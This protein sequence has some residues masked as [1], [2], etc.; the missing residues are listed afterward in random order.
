MPNCMRIALFKV[1]S[2]FVASTMV[3]FVVLYKN[4]GKSAFIASWN[5]LNYM[6]HEKNRNK[7]AGFLANIFNNNSI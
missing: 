7:K 1:I 2:C 6:S 4:P 3:F 5:G